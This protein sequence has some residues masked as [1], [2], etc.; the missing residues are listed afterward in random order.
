MSDFGV[1]RLKTWL[2]SAE[3]A[4]FNASQPCH[5]TFSFTVFGVTVGDANARAWSDLHAALPATTKLDS[6]LVRGPKLVRGPEE[7]VPHE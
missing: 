7:E 3:V 6:L 4:W 1:G 2:V 5:G